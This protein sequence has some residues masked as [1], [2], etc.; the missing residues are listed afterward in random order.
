M[1][2]SWKKNYDEPRQHIRK[3]R[4]HF[5][6][7]GR[8]S[9][10]YVFSSSHVWIWVSDHKEGWE[11]KNCC[12]W[13]IV[14]EKTLE[15]SLDSK[16]IKPVNPKGNQPWLFIEKTDAWS[17]SSDTLDTWCK[18]LTHCKRPWCWEGRRRMLQQR[19][20]WLDGITSSMDMNLSKLQEI[21]KDR[22]AWHAAVYGVA[23]SQVGLSDWTT[24]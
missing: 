3:H 18:E 2:A 22:E 17:W 16:E 5:A 21:V 19:M 6:D 1:L 14:L 4:H 23:K 9:Q 8:Y 20:K 24:K 15:S 11:L 10:S 7:K 13:I 12:F